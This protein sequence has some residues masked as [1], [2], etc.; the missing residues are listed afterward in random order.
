[1]YKL[2]KSNKNDIDRLISYKKKTILE[3]AKDLSDEEINKINNYNNNEINNN[4]ND[5]N[6]IIIDNKNIGSFLLVNKDDGILLDEIFIEEPY[7]NKGIGTNI[8]KDILS[9]NKIVYLWV[10][11]DN[12]A[13]SLYKKL[14]FKI[15]DKT[16]TR[17]Y[18]RYKNEII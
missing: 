5:Y 12:K 18:M 15:I 16:D 10:Y 7:R 3:Y 1:M 13:V 9:N 14:G 2:I 17:Y 4:Y 6:N 11:K 8:I